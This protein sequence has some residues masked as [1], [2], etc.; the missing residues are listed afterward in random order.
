LDNIIAFSNIS[1][2][3]QNSGRAWRIVDDVSLNVRRGEFIT[4]DRPGAGS[5]RS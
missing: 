4:L 2:E 5:R 3:F 1:K